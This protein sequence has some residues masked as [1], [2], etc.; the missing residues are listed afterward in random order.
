MMYLIDMVF[1]C[2]YLA[3]EKITVRLQNKRLRWYFKIREILNWLQFIAILLYLYG[4]PVHNTTERLVS[5]AS[6]ILTK[7]V[8][9]YIGKYYCEQKDM[10]K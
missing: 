10:D 3:C 2:F 7:I 5:F 6:M 8:F 1:I 9:D 4:R